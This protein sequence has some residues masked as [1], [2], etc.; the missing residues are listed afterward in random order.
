MVL[1]NTYDAS[2]LLGLSNF[3]VQQG[4]LCKL[5]LFFQI[6]TT[7]LPEQN[8]TSAR[9]GAPYAVPQHLPVLTGAWNCRC[10]QSVFQFGRIDNDC[11]KVSQ[12]HQSKSSWR[13]ARSIWFCE[14]CFCSS[15]HCCSLR[16]ICPSASSIIFDLLGEVSISP[17]EKKPVLLARC[18]WRGPDSVFMRRPFSE[19]AW[20]GA[21]SKKLCTQNCAW[22][23]WLW[24]TSK[25]ILAENS[26]TF[27]ATCIDIWVERSRDHWFNKLQFKMICSQFMS[28]AKQLRP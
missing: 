27:R 12:V 19:K 25:N 4:I 26:S 1:M 7:T 9:S 5:I 2:W 28:L 22:P 11:I 18:I 17:V 6:S 3:F 15:S 8:R 13:W 10:W 21:S 24:C 23:N 20:S 14:M 16:L